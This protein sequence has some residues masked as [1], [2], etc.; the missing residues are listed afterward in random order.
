[1][2]CIRKKK[3]EKHESV[4]R[5][6]RDLSNYDS[7]A[8]ARLLK[9]QD[10]ETFIEMNDTNVMW[11]YLYGK[12]YDISSIMCPFRKFKQRKNITPWI[13]P[14]IYRA[15]RLRDSY[16]SLFLVTGCGQY[17]C[18]VRRSRNVVNQMILRAKSTFIKSKLRENSTNPRKFW[19]VINGLINPSKGQQTDVHFYDSINGVYVEHGME[20]DFLNY[21]FLNIV[22][23]LG[24]QPSNNPCLGVYDVQT[25]FCFLDNM[26]T[27][28]EVLKLI[29]EIDIKKSSCVEKINTRFCKEAMMCIPDVIC[30]LCCVS[31]ET[32]S[33]PDL[34]TMLFRKMGI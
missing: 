33:I 30:R 11:N 5:I 6:V 31:L 14:E 3:R 21:F 29:K 16:V 7:V 1:M 34:W 8:F 26:P 25:R 32:G 12:M 4:Y 15:M 27:V 19:R 28:P 18:M 2:Y 24:I 22:P 20:P 17:L 10:W 23:N 13:T 9:I